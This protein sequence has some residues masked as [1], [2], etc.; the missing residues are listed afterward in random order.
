MSMLDLH[1]PE[2]NWARIAEGMGIEAS[3]AT[4]SE[5]FAAQYESAMKQRGPRL[6]EALF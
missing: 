6:I 1:H 5:E 2:M 4:T 3:R